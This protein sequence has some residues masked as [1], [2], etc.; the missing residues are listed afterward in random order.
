VTHP[1]RFV[2]QMPI[3][4]STAARWLDGIREVE[5]LGFDAVSVSE[6]L[7]GGWRLDALAAMSAI[8]AATSRLR[9]MSLVLDSDL[10][11]PVLLHKAIATMDFLS[12]GRVDLG[13]GAGWL[14]ADHAAAG[15][16]FARAHVRIERLEEAVTIIKRL[17]AMP[18]VSYAGVHYT[19][20]D[21]EGLPRPTQLPHPPILIG[22]GGPRILGVAA[23]QADIIGVHARLDPAATDLETAR[24]M[25]ETAIAAKVG[26]VR[27]ALDAAGRSPDDVQLQLTIYEC[28]ITDQASARQ[29]EPS[30]F[31]SMLRMNPDEAAR[32]PA[33]LVGTVAQCVDR[34]FELRERFGFNV[35]KLSGDP[36][37]AAP[38]VKSLSGR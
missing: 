2:A 27:D 31:A 9:V 28:R 25:G 38:I 29:G 8:L 12:G 16:P 10:H 3:P 17:F 24:D 33:V 19:V 23:R 18:T 7:T 34:L 13:L 11:N 35:Y 30:R 37:T 21:A 5:G 26:L 1:F 4:A 6:H 32:S 22:G 36:R 15:A 14:E 20:V